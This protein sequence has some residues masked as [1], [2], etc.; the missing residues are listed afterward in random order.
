MLFRRR[1]IALDTAPAIDKNSRL[2]FSNH[3]VEFLRLHDPLL[4]GTEPL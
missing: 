3:S 1:E 4:R 2:Q